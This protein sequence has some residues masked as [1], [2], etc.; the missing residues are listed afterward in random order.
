MIHSAIEPAVAFQ[1]SFVSQA[2]APKR[3]D[4]P[5]TVEQRQA[6][7][8]ATKPEFQALLKE[9]HKTFKEDPAVKDLWGTLNAL[10]GPGN[11]F[12][13]A[14]YQE[15][16]GDFGACEGIGIPLPALLLSKW[17][18]LSQD[19]ELVDVTNFIEDRIDFAA[20]LTKTP[21][22]TRLPGIKAITV[23]VTDKTTAPA[24]GSLQKASWDLQTWAM[25]KLYV[26]SKKD[27][28]FP[29]QGK[30]IMTN[31]V[32]HYL[33][34]IEFVEVVDLKTKS[35]CKSWQLIENLGRDAASFA[36]T[37][38]EVLKQFAT[39]RDLAESPTADK[40]EEF[41]KDQIDFSPD[42]DYKIDKGKSGKAKAARKEENK[43]TAQMLLAHDRIIKCRASVTKIFKD[44]RGKRVDSKHPLM[45]ATKL[46]ELSKKCGD[47]HEKLSHHIE[48]IY[49]QTLS[50]H[51]SA[52]CTHTALKDEI[53]PRLQISFELQNHIT[54]SFTFSEDSPEREFMSTIMAKP[55]QWYTLAQN[56]PDR[57]AKTMHLRS[58]ARNFVRFLEALI[59]GQKDSAL[60]DMLANVNPKTPIHE[61]FQYAKLGMESTMSEY[62]TML[63]QTARQNATLEAI[64][65]SAAEAPPPGGNDAEPRVQPPM[66]SPQELKDTAIKDAR[67]QHATAVMD[68]D[69]I[70]L[71][72]PIMKP[73]VAG[74][75]DVEFC[76]T[77]LNIAT[78]ERPCFMVYYDP[79]SDSV[80]RL[81]HERHSVLTHAPIADEGWIRLLFGAAVD[82][83][84]EPTDCFVAGECM[85]H[86]NVKL[87]KK[88]T[89]TAARKKTAHCTISSL[90]L[91]SLDSEAVVEPPACATSIGK[92]HPSSR[93]STGMCT[94]S[95][96]RLQIPSRTSGV[97]GT[98]TWSPSTSRLPSMARMDCR[99]KRSRWSQMICALRFRTRNRCHCRRT[100][101][102]ML[103]RVECPCSIA[104][105]QTLMLIYM[106]IHILVN[107]SANYVS[108]NLDTSMPLCAC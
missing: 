19:L 13:D 64:E 63:E 45:M 11:T 89:R 42:A 8:L 25:I 30:L 5:M 14:T 76:K 57:K 67:D 31:M 21:T 38:F 22:A 73:A 107:L 46:V 44:C 35:F 79:G 90:T 88:I 26:D 47:D 84:L 36:L 102:S 43:M 93:M 48:V 82:K 68:D 53:C 56:S 37:G 1:F 2:M 39:T 27:A 71:V 16:L 59:T 87:F 54:S 51:L 24:F 69:I 65:S 41:L 100:S 101:S 108:L 61:K 70:W 3:A 95:Q 6:A 92:V 85:T 105:G 9:F 7:D 55:L 23:L 80:P 32:G 96:L 78:A 74:H 106:Y 18:V 99:Q 103:G 104:F 34:N 86:T 66:M 60:D 94:L 28:A 72:Q 12:D 52:R 75:F 62:K 20:L 29:E 17:A 77:R 97:W 83:F 58:V 98:G 10:K 50:G 40:V 33:C 15:K 4:T 91:C 49:I 81:E